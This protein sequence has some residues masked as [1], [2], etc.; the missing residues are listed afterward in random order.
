MSW[1]YE[2][3]KFFQYKN[4]GVISSIDAEQIIMRCFASMDFE[5]AG[6]A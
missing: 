4:L 3:H 6:V 1:K 5:T 2:S